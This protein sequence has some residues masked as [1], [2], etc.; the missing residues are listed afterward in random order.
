MLLYTLACFVHGTILDDQLINVTK[1][2]TVQP[3]PFLRHTGL[4][5]HTALVQLVPV[6]GIHMVAI[7]LS[8]G[9][10]CQQ[11]FPIPALWSWNRLLGRSQVL[12]IA[13]GS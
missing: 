10:G 13:V 5:E 3:A 4:W 9:G 7:S 12:F 11:S 8:A 6:Q 2:V 1:L